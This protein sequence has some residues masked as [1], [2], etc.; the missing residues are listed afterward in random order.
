MGLFF[1]DINTMC[2]Q[3]T[4]E[5]FVHQN[6]YIKTC[7]S[8]TITMILANTWFAP[9]N[10]GHHKHTEYN[11]K[12]LIDRRRPSSSSLPASFSAARQRCVTTRASSSYTPPSLAQDP[13]P[14][15]DWTRYHLQLLFVDRYGVFPVHCRPQH[16]H[17]HTC[18]TTPDRTLGVPGLQWGCLSVWQSG[19]A[20][21]ACCWRFPVASTYCTNIP[22]VH[23]QHPIETH[24]KSTHQKWMHCQEQHRCCHLH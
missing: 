10:T 20:L 21:V 19:M 14:Y 11:H 24:Q 8:L 16:T 23:Q 3:K 22:S 15:V 4:R 9:L 2:E 12:H 17:T 1:S 18:V 7:P 5:V 6:M 13:T